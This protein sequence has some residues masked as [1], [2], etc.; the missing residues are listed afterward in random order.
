MFKV[1]ALEKCNK[2][3][4]RQQRAIYRNKRPCHI[5]KHNCNEFQNVNMIQ[6]KLC[7]HNEFKNST[8]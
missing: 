4:F 5:S 8:R 2:F 1:N 7:D 6:I 3:F